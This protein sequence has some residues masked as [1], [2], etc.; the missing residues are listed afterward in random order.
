M[1]FDPDRPK[2]TFAGIDWGFAIFITVLSMITHLL[3]IGEPNR[4]IFDEVY[5]G[6]FT[7]YYHYGLYFF[8]IHQHGYI[9]IVPRDVFSACNL[10]VN[11]LDKWEWGHNKR[12]YILT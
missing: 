10:H 9:W 1:L 2:F 8:D 5:F 11:I 4:V 6:N 3:M 7:Q 12:H